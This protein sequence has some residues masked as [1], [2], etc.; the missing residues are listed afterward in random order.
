M[1]REF[2]INILLGLFVASLI[3]ASLLG[4]KITTFFGI[5]V[6]VGIFS[7]P[8]TFLI[9]NIVLEAKGK[10]TVKNFIL[11][12]FI[13]MIAVLIFTVV[14]LKVPPAGRFAFS[15]EYQT[16]FSFSLRIIIA[17]LTA[18]LSAQVIN[19]TLFKKMTSKLKH[20]FGWLRYNAAVIVSLFFDTLIFYFI[21]FYHVSPK[22]SALF[23]LK[24]TIPYWLMKILF[25]LISTPFWYAGTRWLKVKDKP[26]EPPMKVAV[27]VSQ[28]QKH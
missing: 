7:Y 22:F 17:S 1:K 5:T 23:I 27:P 21:A 8:I 18:F 9:A 11:T 15:P 3:A 25:S 20:K 10:E 28:P 12:G 4:N 16:V 26:E 19:M 13:S 24:L 2:K 14:S 6:A